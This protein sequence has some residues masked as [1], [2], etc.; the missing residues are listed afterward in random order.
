MSSA[1]IDWLRHRKGT[2]TALQTTSFDRLQSHSQDRAAGIVG[3]D[4]P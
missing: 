2:H 3:G 4:S 1:V